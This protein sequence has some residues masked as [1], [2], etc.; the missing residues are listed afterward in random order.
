MGVL[1]LLLVVARCLQHHHATRLKYYSTDFKPNNRG[2]AGK[3]P[4]K[5]Q[6]KIKEMPIESQVKIESRAQELIALELFRQ[7]LKQLKHYSTT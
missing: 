4:K 5:L 3:M 1:D 2:N 7:N 6:D